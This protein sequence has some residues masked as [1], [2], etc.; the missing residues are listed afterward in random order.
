MDTM[1]CCM[2]I[3]VT[4]F[5]SILYCSNSEIDLKNIKRGGSLTTSRQANANAEEK[6]VLDFKLLYVKFV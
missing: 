6:F 4:S 2:C 5:S 3:Y 1:D